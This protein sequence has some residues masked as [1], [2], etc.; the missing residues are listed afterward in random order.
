MSLNRRIGKDAGWSQIRVARKAPAARSS[1]GRSSHGCLIFVF[2]ILH[3]FVPGTLRQIQQFAIAGSLIAPKDHFE[4]RNVSASAGIVCCVIQIVL[5]QSLDN[6]CGVHVVR[7]RL[8]IGMC[9]EAAVQHRV[10]PAVQASKVVA[11]LQKLR[12]QKSVALWMT[13]CVVERSSRFC[14]QRFISKRQRQAGGSINP[15]CLLF[16][17][18]PGGRIFFT[19]PEGSTK[20]WVRNLRQSARQLRLALHVQPNP[21]FGFDGPWRQTAQLRIGVR[22]R[23]RLLG[24]QHL[25]QSCC[26]QHG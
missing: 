2:S 14:Q 23:G 20:K 18:K 15:I 25:R 4:V 12:T 11:E 8:G 16:P 1:V 10:G 5:V 13:Q 22:R 17:S 3:V 26:C 6:L 7:S 24:L 9:H 19:F 21:S